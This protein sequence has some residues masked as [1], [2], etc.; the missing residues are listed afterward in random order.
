MQSGAHM[1]NKDRPILSKEE[2][3]T[4]AKQ[5]AKQLN[6]TDDKQWLQCLKTVDAKR[7]AHGGNGLAHP[8]EGTDF[9]PI[10]NQKA[11]SN[12]KFNKGIHYI[13]KIYKTY[14]FYL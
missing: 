10:S 4:L 1:Y 14:P 6:C 11:F 8:I 5:W 2:S 12:L 3:I 13:L 9:L 7:L